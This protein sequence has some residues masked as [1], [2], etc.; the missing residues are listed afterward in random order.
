MEENTN[1]AAQA[2][3]PANDSRPPFRRSFGGGNRPPFKRDGQGGGGQG[4]PRGPRRDGGRGG[5]FV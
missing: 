3:T 5:K 1:V 4:G 2:A